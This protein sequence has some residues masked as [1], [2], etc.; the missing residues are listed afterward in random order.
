M[1]GV[2]ID[3]DGAPIAGR[4]VSNGL[5]VTVTDSHGRWDL[6]VGAWSG[7]ELPFVWV[8]RG[9]GFD[10]RDWFRMPGEGP[11]TFRMQPVPGA[12]T[13][14]GHITDLHV[15][16]SSGA[17]GLNEGDCTADRLVAVLTELRDRFG[18]DAVL[19]TGDLTN[20][21]AD[22]DFV[23][24]RRALD[25]SPLPIFH[26]PGNH[27]HYGDYFE[28]KAEDSAAP[29]GPSGRR[30]EAHLGP[31]WWSM[32][33]GGMRIVAIDWHSWHH[34]DDAD[35]QRAWLAADLAS[36]RSGT[37]VLILSHDLMATDFY[38]H[39]ASVAPHVT[40]VGSLSGHWHTARAGRA[41]HGNGEL[42]L[43]TGNPM[44]GS[45]D[46]SPPHA[47]ILEF[48]GSQLSVETRA[49]GVEPQHRTATFRS[50]PVSGAAE[51]TERVRW[52]L[53]LEGVAHLGGP[54]MAA[55]EEQPRCVATW[56]DEDR[57]IGGV[58][59]VDTAGTAVWSARLAGSVLGRAAVAGSDVAAVAIDGQVVVHD[60]STGTRRW[61]VALESG[62]GLWMSSA[63]LL[64]DDV[65]VVGSGPV[66]S[67]L[68]RHDGHVRWRRTDL[69]SH[70]MYPSYGDGLVDTTRV[71]LGM[72]SVEPS[73]Y[74]LDASTG[75]TVWASSSNSGGGSP[76]GSLALG[77]GGRI[78]GLSHRP[79]LFCV[80]AADGTERFRVAVDGHYTWAAPLVTDAGVLVMTADARL[81]CF[82]VDDGTELW[83]V[84][85]PAQATHGFAPYR[86]WGRSSITGPVAGDD[87]RCHVATTDGAVWSIESGS[88]AL[89]LLAQLP[90]AVTAGIV[91]SG[92]QLLVP[93]AD[94]SLWSLDTG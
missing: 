85:V 74:A 42:H 72:P 2:V 61:S 65:V 30:Y 59:A 62:R 86:G 82:D 89:Q 31:R 75:E 46:W 6:P 51:P 57:L 55:S 33:E 48:H 64:T 49:L 24:L 50:A 13:R 37:P 83:R 88:G 67:G 87:G 71:I 63:P 78:Y 52:R 26:M 14:F 34:E 80:D 94:G 70:E 38:E 19:A 54:V 28:P 10:C 69:G 90:S 23:E 36:A 27:D 7:S 15:D 58:T 91:R 11:T 81:V 20:R 43:N 4:A 44:F 76:A 79:E 53:R 93:T 40:I 73:L 77:E 66:F 17:F 45:W 25:R 39:L 60:L 3:Q 68:D 12:R 9:D 29:A 1:Q 5:D 47:R 32:T 92:D 22:E 56:R 8:H 84:D 41:G 16:A 18:C 21:G 35:V